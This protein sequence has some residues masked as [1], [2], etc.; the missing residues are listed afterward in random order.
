MAA[1]NWVEQA[2]LWVL[3]LQPLNSLHWCTMV[4]GCWQAAEVGSQ[5]IHLLRWPLDRCQ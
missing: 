4:Q 2:A 5:R 3:Q 1:D